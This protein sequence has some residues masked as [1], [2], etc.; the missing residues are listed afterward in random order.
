MYM[1]NV[2]R[3]RATTCKNKLKTFFSSLK[4]DNGTGTYLRFCCP[5][6]YTPP[7]PHPV[8]VPGDG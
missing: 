7:L 1:N 4:R 2:K 5:A 6:F 3:R 8:L